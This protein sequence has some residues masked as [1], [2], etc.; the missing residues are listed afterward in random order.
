MGNFAVHLQKKTD[1]RTTDATSC[2][3]VTYASLGE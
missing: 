2:A 3:P 1:R